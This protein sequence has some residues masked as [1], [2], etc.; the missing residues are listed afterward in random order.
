MASGGI[1][2]IFE[3]DFPSPAPQAD[4]YP[5]FHLTLANA[6]PHSRVTNFLA[7]CGFECRRHEYIG[8]P[9]KTNGKIWPFCN[10]FYYETFFMVVLCIGI[11]KILFGWAD[12]RRRKHTPPRHLPQSRQFFGR[13]LSDKVSYK[14]VL[15]LR[16]DP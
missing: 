10:P 3:G 2:G 15:I 12:P 11:Q 7:S 14:G 5:S 9:T 8:I 1:L 4:L 13:N 16:N 6:K